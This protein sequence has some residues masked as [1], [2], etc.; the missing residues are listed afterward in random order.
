MRRRRFA[1]QVIW[2]GICACAMQVSAQAGEPL[3]V[4]RAPGAEN[5]PDTAELAA[6]VE[7]IRGQAAAPSGDYSVE[8]AH[9]G[10]AYSAQVRADRSGTRSLESAAADCSALAQATAVTLALLFDADAARPAEPV[11]SEPVAS[12]PVAPPPPAAEPVRAAG[13]Q[14]GAALGGGVAAGVVRP[15]AAGLL[16]EL[17]LRIDAWR[18]GAG[19]VWLPAGQVELAPGV[20]ELAL[21]AGSVRACYAVVRRPWLRVESCSGVVLGSVSAVASGYTSELPQTHQLYAAL[22]LEL[23]VG[24]STQRVGW[25]LSAC[26]LVPYRRNQFEIEGLGLV[27]DTPA[28]AWLLSMRVNGWLVSN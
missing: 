6:R 21:I 5:C 8:F 7:A 19:V 12:Q 22:P 1:E 16:G 27:Y 24:Q 18:F 20:T 10:G 11:A 14:L 23:T 25:E 28:A 26:L 3:R 9:E 17:G 13:V 15:W 4:E 2:I